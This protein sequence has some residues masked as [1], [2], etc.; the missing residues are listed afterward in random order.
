MK[1]FLGYPVFDLNNL[2]QNDRHTISIFHESAHAFLALFTGRGIGEGGIT[3]CQSGEYI[4]EVVAVSYRLSSLPLNSP[5]DTFKEMSNDIITTF[6][7]AILT[8]GM[9]GQAGRLLDEYYWIQR[10]SEANDILT[11]EEA[12]NLNGDVEC[13]MFH[14]V[15]FYKTRIRERKF[16]K[17]TLKTL[18]M[19]TENLPGQIHEQS[20]TFLSAPRTASVFD[21]IEGDIS[22]KLSSK[23]L[24]LIQKQMVTP[25]LK[26]CLILLC[27]NSIRT[28]ITKIASRVAMERTMNKDELYSFISPLFKENG[29]ALVDCNRSSSATNELTMMQ[30]IFAKVYFGYC[31]SKWNKESVA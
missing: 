19:N 26:K 17:E 16:D 12:D 5:E 25:I 18:A 21:L 24:V 4:A 29:W 22:I 23:E 14:F 10:L 3:A 8:Y 31:K 9:T 1:S 7:P 2:S 28:A 13:T 27:A 20:S 15:N 6:T 11:Y 30:K